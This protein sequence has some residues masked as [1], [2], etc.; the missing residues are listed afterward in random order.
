MA[1]ANYNKVRLQTTGETVVVP[2]L[3]ASTYSVVTVSMVN[4]S[5]T[6]AKVRIAV[7]D[8]AGVATTGEYLEYDTVLNTGGVVER[9]GI[10]VTAGKSV[11]VRAEAVSGTLDV[12]A[13]A[14]GIVGVA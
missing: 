13:Q 7:T 5:E 10:I 4:M 8:T 12:A 9:S 6:Q 2:A 14:Y 3:A 11:T 1:G